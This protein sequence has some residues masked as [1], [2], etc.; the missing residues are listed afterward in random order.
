MAQGFSYT[1]KPIHQFSTENIAETNIFSP[2]FS[3]GERWVFLLKLH[4]TPWLFEVHSLAEHAAFSCEGTTSF[5]IAAGMCLG[6][7]EILCT[8]VRN[9]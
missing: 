7:E 5:F 9:G 6:S 1:V 3:R 2:F 4:E 8:R